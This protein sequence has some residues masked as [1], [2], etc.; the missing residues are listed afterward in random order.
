MSLFSLSLSFSPPPPKTPSLP[1]F[2]PFI[3]YDG[4]HHAQWNL[5]KL[6][7]VD[8]IESLEVL[9]ISG[10]RVRMRVWERVRKKN[11]GNGM[12][13]R[14]VHFLQPWIRR[15]KK[16][17]KELRKILVIK[18]SNFLILIKAESGKRSKKRSW[19]SRALD[20]L[21]VKVMIDSQEPEEWRL[22][23]ERE[24]IVNRDGLRVP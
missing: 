10:G 19:T 16:K 3:P 15:A 2:L 1:T 12:K 23:L 13:Q 21:V 9:L 11:R 24:E 22:I 14:R 4:L 8:Y 5:H 20:I 17:E 6:R 7:G 18:Y